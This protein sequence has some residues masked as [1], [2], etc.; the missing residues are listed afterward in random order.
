M[1]SYYTVHGIEVLG[2]N[3]KGK[4]SRKLFPTVTKL[5]LMDINEPTT[6]RARIP[7]TL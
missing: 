1:L 4:I 2:S 5:K 3:L 6:R 7:F